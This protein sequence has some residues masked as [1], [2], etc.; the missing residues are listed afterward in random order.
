MTAV[1]HTDMIV[2]MDQH[3]VQPPGPVP[4]VLV[5]IP[6]A[7]LVMDPA[8]YQEGACT[9][10]INGLPRAR[11][12]TTCLLCPPHVPV[13]GMF[14]KP[15]THETELAEGSSTVL[16]DGEA[17]SQLGHRV[18]GCH[19]VGGPAPVRAWKAGAAQSLMKDG[20]VALSVPGGA[21]VSVGGAPTTAASRPEEDAPPPE[22]LDVEIVDGEGNPLAGVRYEIT[23]AD[24]STRSGLVSAE[25]RIAFFRAPAG[26]FELRLFT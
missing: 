16:F 20:S 21:P 8:D 26:D 9:V 12:G 18:L 11:A 17:A 23:L 14:V 15:P 1:K 5:P 10:Y 22:W 3:L 19:D 13:G 24:G 4:P 2:G 6:V 25:G 7:G